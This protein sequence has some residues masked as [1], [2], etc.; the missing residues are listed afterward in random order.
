MKTKT[1]ANRKASSRGST[2]VIALMLGGIMLMIAVSYLLMISSQQK[3]VVRSESW[4]ASTGKSGAGRLF[5]S[6]TLASTFTR[7]TFTLMVVRL[8]AAS[9]GVVEASSGFSVLLEP[10]L[11]FCAQGGRFGFSCGIASNGRL[12]SRRH[13]PEAARKGVGVIDD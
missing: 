9:S 6:S 3:L 1:K 12:A 8:C 11:F 4:N 5:S 7:F 2:L 10:V 13:S